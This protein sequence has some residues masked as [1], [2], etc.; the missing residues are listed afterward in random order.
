MAPLAELTHVFLR[1]RPWITQDKAREISQRFWVADP[2]K[3]RVDF[4]WEA[5]H[6][7][8]QGM[9]VTVQYFRQQEQD[10]R[11]M[12][13]ER[14]FILW[15]KYIACAVLIGGLIEVSS[16]I[17]HFYVFIPSWAGW[18]VAFMGFG[19]GLG[20]LAM[21]FRRH[22]PLLQFAIGTLVMG[23]AEALNKLQLLSP[24]S[25]KFASS[26]PFGIV[27]PWI[28]VLVLSITGGLCVLLINYLV[29]VLYK[30]RLRFG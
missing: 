9:Q 23:M 10:L 24:I 2:S 21:W 15:F 17:G 3:A 16:A 4:G 11:E 22:S 5:R 30:R 8:T 7:L 13:L 14:D 29:R 6:N 25:W 26:W 28:R 27:N 1:T 19:L 12:P 18:I 20:T